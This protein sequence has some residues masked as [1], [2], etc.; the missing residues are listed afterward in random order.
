MNNSDPSSLD[1]VSAKAV[2]F[3]AF[4]SLLALV[5]RAVPLKPPPVPVCDGINCFVVLPS[6]SGANDWTPA[7]LAAAAQT[8]LLK[9]QADSSSSQ[10]AS[11][12][13]IAINLSSSTQALA[14]NKVCPAPA[15]E[16]SSSSLPPA[17]AAWLAP[18]H[19]PERFSQTILC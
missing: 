10:A 12:L 13:L 18:R 6:T 15:W 4:F 19:A 16:G 14:Q 1:M 8:K 3:W 5:A 17:K 11:L 2:Y 7:Q 9:L